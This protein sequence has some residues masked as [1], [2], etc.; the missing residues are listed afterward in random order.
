MKKTMVFVMVLSMAG[1]A[2][3][4]LQLDVTGGKVTVS[5]KIEMDTYLFLTACDGATLTNIELGPAAPFWPQPD[6]IPFDFMGCM[7]MGWAMVSNPGEPF[8]EG[9]Y[10]TADVTPA[11]LQETRF[12]EELVPHE[13]CP[14][15]WWAT[16]T[17]TEVTD[18]TKGIVVLSLFS[19]ITGE[20][21]VIDQKSLESRTVTTTVE[22][23]VCIPEPATLSLLGLGT[24]LIRRRR[25]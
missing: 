17:F 23:H 18:I 20:M 7:G 16:R 25:P 21:T 14:P 22:D 5:G 15:G 12:W 8:K 24:V 3:A 1:F 2:G 4:G 6:P 10:V 13:S 9:V 11:T 19:D